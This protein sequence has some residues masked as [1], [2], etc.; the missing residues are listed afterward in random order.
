MNE[1]IVGVEEEGIV[2][3]GV[4]KLGVEGD[5]K[6]KGVDGGVKVKGAKPDFNVVQ[7]EVGV[8]GEKRLVGVGGMW[9]NVSK[10]GNEFYTLKIGKL[11]LLVFENK[12]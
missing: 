6:V 11:K 9:R 4:V 8:S 1:K 3:G 2:K 5:G 7:A 10:N 12:V